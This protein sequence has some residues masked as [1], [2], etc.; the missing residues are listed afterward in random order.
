MKRSRLPVAYV[1]AAAAA[2]TACGSVSSGQDQ[3]GS[4]RKTSQVTVTTV[5]PPTSTTIAPPTT[6]DPVLA[7]GCGAVGF[8]GDQ[9]KMAAESGTS[10]MSVTNTRPGSAWQLV[11]ALEMLPS[12][13]SPIPQDTRGLI[14]AVAVGD[15]DRNPNLAL[16]SITSLARDCQTETG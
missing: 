4:H 2:F 9:I 3:A 7:L 10:V 12:S 5:A 6:T 14:S 16:T 1:V 8:L 15:A 11:T 13:Y